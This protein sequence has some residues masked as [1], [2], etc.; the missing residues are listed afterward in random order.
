MV[1]YGYIMNELMGGFMCYIPAYLMGRGRQ[2]VWVHIHAAVAAPGPQ[3]FPWPPYDTLARYFDNANQDFS[4]NQRIS[5][6][7][8]QHSELV[9]G[10]EPWNFMTF[11]ILG[12]I[13]RTDELIFVRGSETNNQELYVLDITCVQRVLNKRR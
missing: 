6:N 7:K 8:G 11:H 10:L 2:S 13:I 9:G 3:V 1:I 5:V 12:L 4:E